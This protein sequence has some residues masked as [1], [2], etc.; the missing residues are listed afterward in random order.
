MK[1]CSPSHQ[2]EDWDI[3]K[4]LC[5]DFADFQERPGRD[6]C[7]AIS[8]PKTSK[9]PCFIWLR[10]VDDEDSVSG[11]EPDEELPISKN[12][13]EV[14]QLVLDH[15]PENPEQMDW[16]EDNLAWELGDMGWEEPRA[17]LTGYEVFEMGSEMDGQSVSSSASIR[18]D[19]L[20]EDLSHEL[21]LRCHSSYGPYPN[22]CVAHFTKDRPDV[23]VYGSLDIY[24]WS[25]AQ[26]RCVDLDTGVLTLA[27]KL[28]PHFY[29]ILKKLYPERGGDPAG[30]GVVDGEH[31]QD[32]TG[33]S[34]VE[35]NNI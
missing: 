22:E 25:E 7:R 17:N 19:Q 9:V 18:D 33:G 15:I 30:S 16:E 31:K 23:V 24:G 21:A 14:A 6:Y 2:L 12:E 35:E 29:E 5:G 26:G 4:L 28:L 20:R 10:F 27:I 3:H 11:E 1:Y 34:E 13:R 32:G 8:F